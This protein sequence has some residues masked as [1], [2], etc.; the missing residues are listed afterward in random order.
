MKKPNI[1]VIMSDQLR[2]DALGCSGNAAVRTPNIDRLAAGGARFT[3]AY[4]PN[5]L[6]VPARASFTTGCYPHKSAGSKQ[7]N[8]Q[9]R[10]GYPTIGEEMR[11]RGYKTY[12]MGK[13]HYTPYQPPGSERVTHGL[14][15]VELSESG[16]YVH[17]FD[18]TGQLTGMEEYLDYLQENGWG[19]YTRG[20]GLGNN[21]IF[22][23][24]SPIPE[25][26]YVDTWVADR[27]IHYLKQHSEQFPGDPFF[28][29]ASFPKP[30]SAY[31]PP[32][33][34]DQLYHPHDM[35]SP[36]GDISML[37]ERGLD[38]LE[39]EYRKYGWDTLSPQAKKVIKAHYYGLVGLQDKLIGRMLDYLEQ[40]GLSED[41][42]VVFTSDHGDMLGD[43]GL[44][45]KK[46][47][48]NGSVKIPL[49]IR[50]PRA[51]RSGIVTDEL[52][53]LQDLL[54]T[55]LGLT[56]EPLDQQIDGVNLLPVLEQDQAVRRYFVSQS[57]NEA[58]AQRYM[59][60]DKRWKYMYHTLGGVQELYDLHEDPHECCNLAGS[61]DAEIVERQDELRNYLLTW[62][63][64]NED[65]SML[66]EGGLLR[67]EKT[68]EGKKQAKE[69]G[70]GPYGH[71]GRRFV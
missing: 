42:I 2:S 18:P 50:Y 20:H 71:F 45:F 70:K 17:R 14:E 67:V 37:N 39:A 63:V 16:R 27:T 13:L 65:L 62:C 12:A 57:N 8:G 30:H 15:T 28:M 61:T 44:Y 38:L 68:G 49:I 19:G 32:R 51:I 25:E 43:F 1:L 53:G 34:Y 4:T 3:N 10:E 33:P 5:P 11:Q 7:N 41:T 69:S 47:F 6:C 60:A 36:I 52:A 24:P 66:Q 48:Y 31:D 55:L 59:V 64:D 9:I 23:A 29:W 56:G 21:D 35:P 40:N 26:H 58:S 22:P 54:P 46:V